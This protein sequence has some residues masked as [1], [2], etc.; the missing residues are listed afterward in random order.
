MEVVL[1]YF[2]SGAP[3]LI[4]AQTR[5]FGV[6]YPEGGVLLSNLA[7]VDWAMAASNELLGQVPAQNAI[8]LK[9]DRVP[10]LFA[11]VEVQPKSFRPG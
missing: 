2:L 8:G 5:E 11:P 6:P 4:G 3:R 10:M 9:L 7:V 1:P